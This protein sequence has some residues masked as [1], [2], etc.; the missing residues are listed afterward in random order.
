[1][2]YRSTSSGGPYTK[3]ANKISRQYYRDETVVNG[4]TYYY[5]VTAVYDAGES[6]YS[7]EAQGQ[8]QT[9]GYTITSGWAS[10]TPTLDGVINAGEWAQAATTNITYP[11]YSGT[12][13]LYA[14]NNSTQLFLAVDDKRDHSLDN[15]DQFAIFFDENKDREWPLSS[16]SGEGNFWLA[17]DGNTS[18]AFSL[19]GPRY[20]W[21]PDNLG[22]ETRITPP[23]VSQGISL[24]SGN[25]QYEGSIHLSTSPLNA[26]PG[27]VIGLLV[28]TYDKTPMDF[29]SF[30]PQQADRLKVITPDIQTWGQAPFS[31]GD[32]KL[33][34]SAGNPILSVNPT[35]L[36]F[37]TTSTSKTFAISNTGT[38]TLSWNA[39]E[40]PDQTW[41]TSVSPPSGTGNATVTVQVNR[42]GLSAGHYTGTI[43][44]SSNGGTQNVTVEMDVQ[45][46]VPDS[47]IVLD[48]QGAPGSTGNLVNIKLVNTVPVAGVQFTVTDIPDLLTATGGNITSRTPGFTASISPAGTVVLFHASGNLIPAGSGP[49]LQIIYDVATSAT[50][51]TNVTL[52]LHAVTVSKQDASPLPVVEKDGVF[53]IGGL[54]GDVNGD[55]VRNILDIIMIVNIILGKMTPTPEQSWAADCNGDGTINILDIILLIN[56]ILHPPLAQEKANSDLIPPAPIE[57]RPA[58]NKAQ[59]SLSDVSLS[60]G[61]Q[62]EL[63]VTLSSDGA[64]AG[65]QVKI[66]YPAAALKVSAPVLTKR[67]QEMEMAVTEE[68]GRLTLLLYSSQGKA[69][70]S[71]NG[72][73]FNLPIEAVGTSEGVVSLD[74]EEVILAD[75]QGGTMEV[76]VSPGSVTVAKPLPAHYELGQ[77][78]PNPF[79]PETTIEYRLPHDS[80][81][82]LKIFNL[83]GKEIR[84][85]VAKNQEAG[86]HKVQWDGRDSQGQKVTSGVYLYQ[87][88]IQSPSGQAFTS[89]RKLVVIR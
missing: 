48:G 18:S 31:Y 56:W 78:Y 13:T 37:G 4:Q 16:P 35:A 47:L 55:G 62:A 7:N 27:N 5:V 82:T 21:W 65:V 29:N 8:S 33:A 39:Y 66:T 43:T 64:V 52:D 51:G 6:N 34:S 32:L 69:I 22:W 44:V 20:G 46:A 41:I 73:I 26:S 38:G 24:A 23:G 30:W 28:F 17:W 80:Q 76:T 81:V 45:G 14:M 88:A 72:A 49:I 71:G 59:L 84:V 83:L 86:V 58:S 12:V 54:K 60:P 53:A 36:N 79:N 40:N 15:L 68:K 19:F 10:S 63:P 87:I 89:T 9:N 67:A 57:S 2:V 77:N 3:I 11:G 1:N 85:L 25:V 74:V 75:P 61:G 70:A 50:I 42:S